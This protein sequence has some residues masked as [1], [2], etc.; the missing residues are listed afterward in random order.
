MNSCPQLLPRAR[1]P[2][3]AQALLK[4]IHDYQGHSLREPCATLA[5]GGDGFDQFFDRGVGLVGRDL[6]GAGGYVATAAV[7]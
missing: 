3:Q 5:V 6:A 7:L 1:R 4:V 2:R